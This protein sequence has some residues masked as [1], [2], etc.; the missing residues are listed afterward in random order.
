M[1]VS[2]KKVE[3]GYVVRFEGEDAV[4]GYVSK[5]YVFTRMAQVVKF[6]RENLK[7]EK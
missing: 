6:L 1:E 3:N 7:E 4:E 5:E 2:V